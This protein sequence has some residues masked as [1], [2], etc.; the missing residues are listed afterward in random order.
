MSPS[1]R[2]AEDVAP[3]GLGLLFSEGRALL[4][5][6]WF[7]QSLPV[8]RRAPRGD[9]HPVMVLPGFTASDVST[10]LLRGYLRSQGYKVRGWGL[11][12]NLGFTP[13]LEAKMLR[14]LQSFHWTE[15]EKVSLVGW[16]LGGIFARELARSHPQMVRQVISLG[17]PFA[18][19]PR[20]TNVWRVYE[21]VTGQPIDQIDRDLVRRMRTAPPVPS[22]AIYSTGDGIASWRA[23]MEPPGER[24]DNV[25]VSG[26]HCGLGV[27]PMALW[28]VA[29]RLAQP[30]GEWRKF[31]LEG[32]AGVV[33]P[34]PR[35][36]R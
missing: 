12:R 11:G 22:T 21:R 36:A 15:D 20:A 26:S 23:C 25:R 31:N 28:V 30:E 4:E 35:S 18:A 6:G 1:V 17:S 29:D 14:R 33:F 5:L 32:L 8:L 19:S 34:E 2:L 16:S 10:S 24:T 9:G 13:H 27:N 7:F 3:P